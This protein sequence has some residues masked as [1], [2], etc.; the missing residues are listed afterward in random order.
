MEQK[1]V[2]GYIYPVEK[3]SYVGVTDLT[4]YAIG[5]TVAVNLSVN[6]PPV[7]SSANSEN[8]NSNQAKL[9]LTRNQDEGVDVAVVALR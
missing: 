6:R 8:R 7:P 1:R 4:A 2:R 5:R 3:G 9:K